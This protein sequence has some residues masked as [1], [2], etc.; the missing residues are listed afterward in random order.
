MKKILLIPATA[1]VMGTVLFLGNL[2]YSKYYDKPGFHAVKNVKCEK[3][4]VDYLNLEK[5]IRTAAIGPEGG[6]LQGKDA[7]TGKWVRIEFPKK[8]FK[9]DTVFSLDFK[10]S[11]YKALR[12]TKSP[13]TFTVSPAESGP[14]GPVQIKAV[15]QTDDKFG[16]C[17]D[18]FPVP[19]GITESGGL[20]PVQLVAVKEGYFV[21]ETSRFG[22]F[23]WVYVV[24]E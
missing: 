10:D 4:E 15:V 11:D 12:G 2:V 23:S 19:Y 3:G 9:K 6:M 16:I 14:A 7:A 24:N 21:M 8:V 1:I 17:G 20:Y 13:T 22:D 18:V 5:E